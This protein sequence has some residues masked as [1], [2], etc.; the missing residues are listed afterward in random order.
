MNV[1]PVGVDDGEGSSAT[2]GICTLV[3][4]VV[5]KLKGMTSPSK[6][7][8][9]EI[10]SVPFL[11][12]PACQ[13]R[14]QSFGED[15]WTYFNNMERVKGM[16][17]AHTSLTKEL[18]ADAIKT[19]IEATLTTEFTLV[20]GEDSSALKLDEFIKKRAMLGCP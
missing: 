10:G 16:H 18:N 14:V 13:T 15:Q 4:G 2:L 9:L 5:T 11:H 6:G 20:I 1:N 7:R 3:G 8:P 17:S 19:A 12:S